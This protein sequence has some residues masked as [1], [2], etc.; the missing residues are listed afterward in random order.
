MEQALANNLN[1]LN[2]NKDNSIE[3]IIPAIRFKVN[4]LTDS[5]FE[6]NKI[7]ALHFFDDFAPLGICVISRIHS[8]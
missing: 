3:I 6:F 5:C 4:K 1:I 7:F 2:R 8:P